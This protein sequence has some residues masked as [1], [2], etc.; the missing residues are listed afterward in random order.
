VEGP[1]FLAENKA[2]EGVKTTA[3]GLQYKI[4]H[5][6]TGPTPKLTDR[7]VVNFTGMTIDGREF[8]NSY[9][10]GH[11]ETLPI[12]RVIK[13]WREGLQLM[14]EGSKFRLFVPADLA[15]GKNGAGVIAPN[16]TLIFNMELV[17]IVPAPATASVDIH[18]S[19][20]APTS[21]KAP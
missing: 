3:S 8:E 11:A 9:K 4:L 2:R 17:G 16:A 13:G 15:Y 5:E 10:S 19:P 21:T 18:N 7:V 14:N 6:G 12:D 1:R 20:G